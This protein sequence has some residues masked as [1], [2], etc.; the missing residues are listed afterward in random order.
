MKC[1]NFLRFQ[2]WEWQIS[3]L[4]HIQQSICI[5]TVYIMFTIQF[6]SNPT[7][8]SFWSPL[9]QGVLQTWGSSFNFGFKIKFWLKIVVGYSSESNTS[10]SNKDWLITRGKGN[11]YD[12]LKDRDLTEAA[13]LSNMEF[14]GFSSSSFS[15][16]SSDLSSLSSSSL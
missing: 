16:S 2:H 11:Y 4:D 14:L 1:K 5:Y 13:T 15:S 9:I 6:N 7:V 8:G 10:S 12:H 3:C